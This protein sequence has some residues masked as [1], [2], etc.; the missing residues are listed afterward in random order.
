ETAQPSIDERSECKPD[1]KR[2]RDSAQPQERAQPSIDVI[3]AALRTARTDTSCVRVWQRGTIE[4]ITT[5]PRHTV[6]PFDRADGP[7]SW[8]GA[9]AGQPAG[10][11][12]GTDHARSGDVWDQ[13]IVAAP[14]VKQNQR[15]AARFCLP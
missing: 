13:C 10:E 15:R 2:K 9:P 4:Q 7:D 14:C 11:Q 5:R 3:T 8:H 6:K 12:S 1:A